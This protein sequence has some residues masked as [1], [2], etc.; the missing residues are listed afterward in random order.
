[1]FSL[2][3]SLPSYIYQRVLNLQKNCEWLYHNRFLDALPY[4]LIIEN[5]NIKYISNWSRLIP[6]FLFLPDFEIIKM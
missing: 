2:I 5:E 6:C 4:H 3:S 1:M